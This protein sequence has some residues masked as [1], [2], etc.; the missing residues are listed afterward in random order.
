[1]AMAGRMGRVNT[2]VPACHRDAS[3]PHPSKPNPGLLGAWALSTTSRSAARRL[4]FQ[5]IVNLTDL[6][7]SLIQGP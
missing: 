2:N 4:L 1:M 3:L 7:R 6:R 5:Q